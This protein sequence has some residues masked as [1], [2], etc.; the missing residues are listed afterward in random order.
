MHGEYFSQAKCISLDWL[1]GSFISASLDWL[2]GLHVSN[3]HFLNVISALAQLTA[4]TLLVHE[5]AYVFGL[6]LS[7]NTIQSSWILPFAIWSMS[8]KATSKLI[9]AY[10]HFHRLLYGESSTPPDQSENVQAKH[11]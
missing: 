5:F 11:E 7:N 3:S 6:R 10:Y 9:N 8:P 4:S 2:F 1:L